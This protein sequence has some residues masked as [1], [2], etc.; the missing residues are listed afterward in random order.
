M[1][2][3][4]YI[5]LLPIILFG[6]SSCFEKDQLVPKHISGNVQTSEIQLTEDYKYQ[7]YFDLG[8]NKPVAT[9]HKTD[10]DLAFECSDTGYT[11]LLNSSKFMKIVDMGLSDFNASFDTTGADWK[12]D[13]P[14]GHPDSTAFGIWA[15]F[16]LNPPVSYRSVYAL[17]LGLDEEGN[18]LGFR[19]VQLLSYDQ[20]YFIKYALL[21]GS[22]ADSL[23]IAKDPSR[24]YSYFS[25][26]NGGTIVQI[27]PPKNSWD[28]HFTQYSTILYTDLGEAVQ[29]LVL[30][31]LL[32]PHMVESAVLRNTD[33]TKVDF[34]M[35]KNLELLKYRDLIGYEW[36]E[37]NFTSGTYEVNSQDTYI[38]RD[39][40]GYLFKFRFISFY[41]QQ[42]DKG[43]PTIELQQL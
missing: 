13:E 15:D 39:T 41:N 42:G 19:K 26:K 23:I 32:N 25:F 17:D 5:F 9:N 22:H 40:D 31:V 1:K 14:S 36:K 2:F 12:F 20:G 10:W 21:D 35:V 11:I 8:S 24:N 27:E 33:F 6:T 28:I 3:K 18:I 37:Y 16:S 4:L 34:E 7:V 29:Y 38:I 43:F 30:G